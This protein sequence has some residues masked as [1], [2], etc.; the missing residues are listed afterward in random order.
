MLGE[1]WE[2]DLDA[3]RTVVVQSNSSTVRQLLVLLNSLFVFDL[4]WRT[5]CYYASFVALYTMRYRGTTT[6]KYCCTVV[7]NQWYGKSDTYV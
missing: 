5:G 6:T 7:Q 3:S 1:Q 4:L 2:I